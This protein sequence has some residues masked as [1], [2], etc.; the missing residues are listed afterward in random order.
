MTSAVVAFAGEVQ[1]Q[2]TGVFGGRV[3]SAGNGHDTTEWV[4][5]CRCTITPWWPWAAITVRS[6][7]V[8]ISSGR[9]RLGVKR[10][11]SG[12]SGLTPGP[13]TSCGAS[14]AICE[15]L[16]WR[17]PEAR[18][19]KMERDRW[20]YVVTPQ[21]RDVSSE[22]VKIADHSGAGG[23]RSAGSKRRF[24]P[25]TDQVTEGHETHVERTSS[26]PTP[27]AHSGLRSGPSTTP[28]LVRRWPGQQRRKCTTRAG[29]GEDVAARTHDDGHAM[30]RSTPRASM[31]APNL[32]GQL[33]PGEI[34]ASPC[35]Q[36][37]PRGDAHRWPSSSPPPGFMWP[38][39]LRP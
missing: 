16:G 38:G 34:S 35:G 4:P 13:R 6:G 8:R 1:E 24:H 7:R 37:E 20:V 27:L 36:P 33:R 2:L 12:R 9:A 31:S 5:E 15:P 10:T 30:P 3:R 21:M 17:G 25:S 29:D 22:A 32:L 26:S 18:T 39:N 14:I 23:Y 28:S 19:W 11:A